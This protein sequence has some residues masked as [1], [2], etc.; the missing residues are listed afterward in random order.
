[1]REQ[2]EKQAE[3]REQK[4]VE[5][6]A[7]P[8]ILIFVILFAGILVFLYP[9]AS[10]LLSRLTSTV[11]ISGY[12][13]AVDKLGE[14]EIAARKARARAYND[15]LAGM[16]PEEALYRTEEDTQAETALNVDGMSGYIEIPKI[17]VN[18]P[19]FYKTDE[20]SLQKGVCHLEH[21]SLPV[22]GAGSHCVLSGHTGLPSA[23]LLTDLDQLKEG[24]VFYLHILDEVLA[25]QVDKITVVLPEETEDLL[26]VP[27][28][29]YTTLVTCTP[30][31]IND[32][33][34]LVRGMR[35]PYTP[36]ETK[37]SAG[38]LKNLSMD[39][40]LGRQVLAVGIVLLLYLI[41]GIIFVIIRKMRR[42]GR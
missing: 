10:D 38:T 19:I 37:V 1:M 2:A 34:L 23:E 14:E 24:D 36:E 13:K 5:K 41:L 16:Q 30:Y 18:L 35:I 26:I 17:E 21:T 11:E 40:R 39:N 7:K 31:G 20:A 15:R 22:G 28:M 12:D 3:M 32:H 9:K 6:K 29:D 4:E 33:R 25:Y 8:P 27:G 42:K